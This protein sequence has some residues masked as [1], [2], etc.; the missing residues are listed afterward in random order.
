MQTDSPAMRTGREDASAVE[1]AITVRIPM[2]RQARMMR[3]AISPRLAMRIL[4]NIS[5]GS[6]KRLHQE[7]RLPELDRL[8]VLHHHLDDAARHL[9]LD[10]V[11]QLHRLDDAEHLAFLHYVTLD[12]ERGSVGLRR[13]VEGADHRRLHRDQVRGR[14]HPL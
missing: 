12:D 8:A 4:W 10:L 2:S 14:L 5:P 9:G 6:A 13:A 3:S 7:E 1:G 11:H